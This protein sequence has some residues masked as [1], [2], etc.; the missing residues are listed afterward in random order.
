MAEF[1][2]FRRDDRSEAVL[3]AR[4][5]HGRGMSEAFR[6]VLDRYDRICRA[7]LAWYRGLKPDWVLQVARIAS[8]DEPS[9]WVEKF[10]SEF[11]AS[12]GDSM[13]YKTQRGLA[14]KALEEAA[15]RPAVGLP[16][17]DAVQ[18]ALAE[19]DRRDL[20]EDEQAGLIVSFLKGSST[21]D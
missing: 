20:T 21:D 4:A 10:D 19:I 3:K 17:V 16:L 8:K 15:G 1:F 12:H 9:A 6:E 7:P 11:P 14:R 5:R 2:H 13:L 18:R